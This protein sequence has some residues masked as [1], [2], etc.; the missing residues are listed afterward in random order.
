ML[1][2]KIY[3]LQCPSCHKSTIVELNDKLSC[4]NC[5]AEFPIMSPN[6]AHLISGGND[7]S[8]KKQEIQQ[9]WGDL[10]QQWYSELDKEL[11]PD[12]LHSHLIEMEKLF[13]QRRMLPVVE[14]DLANL[15]GKKVLEIGSGGGGHSMLFKKY[16][17]DMTSVDLTPERVVSTAKKFSLLEPKNSGVAFVADAENLPFQN[18][19][20]DIVY[21]NGV[22]HH[23]EN[24]EKCFDEVYRVL[25]KDGKAVIMLYSRHSAQ[26]WCNT[27]IKSIVTGEFF[28]F[29]EKEWLGR[30]SEGKPKHGT[31]KNPLTRVYSANELKKLLY[32]FN[33]VSLRKNGFL[34]S[35]LPLMAGVRTFVKTKILGIKP[36]LGGT[37]VYG[38]PFI[39][40]GKIETM[41]APYIGWNWD[42]VITKK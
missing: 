39:G 20:F 25:K 30:L 2:Q 11:T 10:Y 36:S 3:L 40:E 13:K 29:P 26:F 34:F 33:I 31:T 16:G 17:A 9:F 1:D 14:M 21:S 5:S 18:E 23:S 12:I 37:I 19:T 32:K 8:G 15:K 35:Q 6:S 28:K 4:Q 41:L 22:L 38:A 7:L 27:F 42:I 24:T